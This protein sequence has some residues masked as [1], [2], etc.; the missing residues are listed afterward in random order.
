[1]IELSYQDQLVELRNPDLTDTQDHVF[2]VERKFDMSGRPH[3]WLPSQTSKLFSITVR[4]LAREKTLELR[5]FL[6]LT[7]GKDIKYRD[8]DAVLWIGRILTNPY[9]II[10]NGDCEDSITIQFEGKLYAN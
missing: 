7:S 4:G 10:A 6:I 1:M 8:Y 2:G 3:T 5:D 9:T